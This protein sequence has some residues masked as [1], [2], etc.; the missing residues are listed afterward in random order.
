MDSKNL[1]NLPAKLPVFVLEDGVLFPGAVARLETEPAGAQHARELLG[2]PEK[3]AVVALNAETDLGVHP[4]AALARVEAVGA[5]GGVIVAVIG[6]GREVLKA[7]HDIEGAV[8]HEIS[9]VEREHI[10]RK[11]ME[12]IQAEL[13]EGPESAEDDLGKKLAALKLPDEIRAQVE[14]ELARLKKLPE[15]S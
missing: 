9:K 5:D 8:Q 14:K 3:R 12:A 6:R 15:S 1:K 13:G 10:L 7:A 11:K 4:I 2:S